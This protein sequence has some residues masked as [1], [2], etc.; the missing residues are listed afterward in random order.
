MYTFVKSVSKFGNAIMPGLFLSLMAS[1]CSLKQAD[2]TK[3]SGSAAFQLTDGQNISQPD[4]DEYNPYVIKKS[5][6]NLIVVFGSDRSCSGCTAGKHHILVSTSAAG[7]ADNGVL[8]L[9]NVPQALTVASAEQSWDTAV[10]FAA[11]KTSTGIRIFV[12]NAAG[13]IVYADLDS[14]NNVSGLSDIN[15]SSW[16]TMKV[17]GAAADATKIFARNGS[18]QIY[19]FNPAGSDTSLTPLNSSQGSNGIVQVNSAHVPRQDAY[20][21]LMGN[22]V[23][24]SSFMQMGGQVTGLNIALANAHV[25]IRNISTLYSANKQG[26]FIFLSGNQDGNSK[27]DLFVAEGAPPSLLWDQTSP[28]PGEQGFNPGGTAPGNFMTFQAANLVLGSPN[29]ISQGGLGSFDIID[30]EGMNGILY[31]AQKTGGL[32]RVFNLMPNVNNAPPSYNLTG[33]NGGV[34]V[35]NGVIMRTQTPTGAAG[36]LLF[37]NPIPNVGG[38]FPAPSYSIGTTGTTCSQSEF[39]NTNEMLEAAAGR[40]LLPDR[41][42]HRLMI[43]N[44]IPV[45]GTQFP[46]IVLGQ[47]NFTTCTPGGVSATALDTP[48]KPW[49]NGQ[50]LAVADMNNHRVLI[51]NSFPTAN[52]QAADIVLG[53]PNF[54]SNT[55]NNAGPSASSLNAPLAVS[56]DGNRF[57]VLDAGNNRVLIWNSFPTSNNQPANV[58][59]GQNDFTHITANDDNQNNVNDTPAAPESGRVFKSPKA[60]LMTPNSLIVS[61]FAHERVLIFHAQ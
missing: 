38:A 48:G 42:N 4:T 16:K 26:E 57:A 19:L 2:Q 37:F 36:D 51:W 44:A 31:L 10:S 29:F 24:T 61:D 52:G 15:N 9:F 13:D 5:D 40:L 11:I 12:N 21:T 22:Q 25:A 55:P 32:L 30:I 54:A 46:N 3:I 47:A 8:P 60:M 39:A 49:T 53:Q 20:L 35:D 23:Q 56:S 33:F 14:G 34:A 43:W 41:N 50:K 6:G 58:V 7:Y 28:K 17:I 45:N 18:G 1:A 59:L 27:Q